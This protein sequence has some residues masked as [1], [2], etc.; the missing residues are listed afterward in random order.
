MDVRLNELGEVRGS[1]EERREIALAAKTLLVMRAEVE[2][3]R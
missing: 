1:V 2:E 3:S